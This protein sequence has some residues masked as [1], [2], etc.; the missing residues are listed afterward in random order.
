MGGSSLRLFN[1]ERSVHQILGGG[2]VADVILWRKSNV[3]VGILVATLAAWVVFEK[4]G[5]T[6]L[7]LVSNVLLLL[8]IILF[9]WAKAA[10]T[11]GRPAPPLPYLQLSEDFVNEAAAF[12]R[13]RVNTLLA[14]SH[15]ISLGKDPVLFVKVAAWLWLVSSVGDWADFLT[16]GYTSLVFILTVPALYEKYEDLI[17][18]YAVMTLEK[19]RRLYARLDVFLSKIHN[20]VVEKRKLE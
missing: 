9:L 1:R 5:Y 11:L 12:V 16:L 20:W 4:S 14:V 8:F 7:S 15:D 13:S 3:T 10:A 17:D 19:L 18:K 2:A 6:L